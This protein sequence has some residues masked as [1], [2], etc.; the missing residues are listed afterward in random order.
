MCKFD[1]PTR[2]LTVVER[3]EPMRFKIGTARWSGAEIVGPGPESRLGWTR[4]L[5]EGKHKQAGASH[6]FGRQLAMSLFSHSFSVQQ[7][8]GSSR[9]IQVSKEQLNSQPHTP[10]WP[11][12]GQLSGRCGH[13]LSNIV[14][15]QVHTSDHKRALKKMHNQL[16]S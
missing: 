3:R 7:H 1:D 10:R 8:D 6:G 14:H 12:H 5:R 2:K 9:H 16:H 13:I 15:I 11:G 4:C